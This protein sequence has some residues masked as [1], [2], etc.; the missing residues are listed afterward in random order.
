[1]CPEKDSHY[2]NKFLIYVFVYVS[3]NMIHG[4][5]RSKNVKIPPKWVVGVYPRSPS[6]RLGWSKIVNLYKTL[7]KRPLE[8]IDQVHFGHFLPKIAS[9]QPIMWISIACL[10]YSIHPVNK[11]QPTLS[12]CLYNLYTYTEMLWVN[13]TNSVFVII[14]FRFDEYIFLRETCIL[15]ILKN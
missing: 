1:M 6:W 12:K 9:K 7:L 15:T 8:W 13:L 3:C 11:Y 10:N 14:I 5:A 4:P 2:L